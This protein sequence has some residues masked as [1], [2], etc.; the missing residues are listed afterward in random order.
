MK[1]PLATLFAVLTAGC[2]LGANAPKTHPKTILIIRHAEK[3]G[4]D[5]DL[6][7][8]GK[9]RSGRGIPELFKK[10]A[11]RPKPFPTPDFIFAA[12]ASGG[13]QPNGGDLD[14]PLEGSQV[15]HQLGLQEQG[16]RRK[17]VEE[18]YS[19]P[20]YAGKTVLICW[21][22]GMIQEL[23]DALGV[24]DAPKFKSEVFDQV[25]VVT[26]DEKGKAQLTIKPQS[27]L[28]GDSKK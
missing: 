25:W 24:T 19:K 14:A 13:K 10:S 6:A 21:H 26:F 4:D 7:P 12:K 8:E 9:K 20:K 1:T 17:L 18:L 3:T 15:G 11:T 23:A 2:S 28:P 16:F 22:H 27:L 5:G